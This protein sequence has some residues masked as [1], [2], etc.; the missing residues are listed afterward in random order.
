MLRELYRAIEMLPPEY[1]EA[2]V[3]HHLSG[4]TIEQ[5]SELM[6]CSIGTT[7]A[8]VSRGRAWI[9]ERFSWRGS[10][11]TAVG[12]NGLLALDAS[13]NFAGLEVREWLSRTAEEWL[14]DG[15]GV[16]GK[17]AVAAAA[18]A[19]PVSAFCRGAST[20][21]SAT[22]GGGSSGVAG[23]GFV[24]R[25]AAVACLAGVLIPATVGAGYLYLSGPT[26]RTFQRSGEGSASAEVRSA[27]YSQ[28]PER[29]SSASSNS[30]VPEPG[31]LSLLAATA[32][33]TLRRRRV[34]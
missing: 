4:L 21:L 29:S 7:A 9:R 15:G 11:L 13:R 30:F 18:D 8:R 28:V 22:G 32:L 23:L 1:R 16:G 2:I 24:A 19:M 17:A 34:R 10:T 25:M 6:A 20:A 27:G 3:L 31:T 5:V 14:S 33:A 26:S 12:L